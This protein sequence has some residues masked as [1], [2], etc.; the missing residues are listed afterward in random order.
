M[1]LWTTL[2]ADRLAA[3]VSNSPLLERTLVNRMWSHFFGYGFTSNV[4]D[5]GPHV[6]VST[7]NYLNHLLIKRELTNTI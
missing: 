7:L 1:E 4:D 3:L 5:M 2:T 6:Q